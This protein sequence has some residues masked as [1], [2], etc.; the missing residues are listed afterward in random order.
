[1]TR[2]F[3]VG[4]AAVLGLAMAVP[5]GFA[6]DAFP[7]ASRMAD[8]VLSLP[9]GPQLSKDDVAGVIEAVRAAA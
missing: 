6:Q 3:R 4:L 5:A 9:M 7:I 1:M 2:L 8:E